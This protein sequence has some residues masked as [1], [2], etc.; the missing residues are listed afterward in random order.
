M[1]GYGPVLAIGN[2][3]TK[4]DVLPLGPA[5]DFVKDSVWQQ[6]ATELMQAAALIVGIASGTEG[7]AWEIDTIAKLGTAS[8]FVLLLPP[9]GVKELEARWRQLA[10]CVKSELIPRD[11]D[12]N[13]FAR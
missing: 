4:R 9:V 3:R 1:W 5:L 12:F 10:E 2:P 6:K 7:L 11:V 13:N 8:K